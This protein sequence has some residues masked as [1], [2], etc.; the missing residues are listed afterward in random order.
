MCKS[1]SIWKISYEVLD[2][3]RGSVAQKDLLKG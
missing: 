3:K 1:I 2:Q